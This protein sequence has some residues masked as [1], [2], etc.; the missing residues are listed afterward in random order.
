MYMYIIS[1]PSS[2]F[3][4]FFLILL[5]AANLMTPESPFQKDFIRLSHGLYKKLLID[6]C[7]G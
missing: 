3:F 6:G 2:V 7:S 5:D 4:S 1:Y